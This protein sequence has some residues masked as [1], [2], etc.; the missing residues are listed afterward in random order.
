MNIKFNY[1][2]KLLILEKNV[3]EKA[4]AQ[5]LCLAGSME[6]YIYKIKVELAKLLI[7]DFL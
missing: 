2:I 1:Y 7:F 6:S 4:I 5:L 3:Q